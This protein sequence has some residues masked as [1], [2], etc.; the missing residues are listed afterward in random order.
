ML[1]Y[2]TLPYPLPCTLTHRSHIRSPIDRLYHHIPFTHPLTNRLLIAILILTFFAFFREN[3]TKN[4]HTWN[5]AQ[6]IQ[7]YTRSSVSHKYRPLLP[8][9]LEPRHRAKKISFTQQSTLLS[10][11]PPVHLS[12]LSSSHS[13]FL[14]LPGS[15]DHTKY[16]HSTSNTPCLRD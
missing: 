6:T 16:S 15:P 7:Q 13:I 9:I 5:T 8:Y 12:L 11:L 10:L 4:R 14:L 1:E 3:Q 2:P